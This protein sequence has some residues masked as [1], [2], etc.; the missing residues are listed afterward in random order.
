MG[1][2]TVNRRA[3]VEESRVWIGIPGV[4][5]WG[6]SLFCALALPLQAQNATETVT[7]TLKITTSGQSALQGSAPGNIYRE[8]D[9]PHTGD[10]WLV[11]RDS[12]N[13]AGPGRMVQVSKA[14]TASGAGPASSSGSNLETKSSLPVIHSG[15]SLIVIE[16]TA[17]VSEQLEAVALE[18]A[19]QGSIFEVRLNIGGR[20]YRA[21][22]TGPGRARFSE[23]QGGQ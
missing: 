19:A 16:E 9:D 1:K 3:R 14:A 18:S 21:V 17:A 10:R 22:A 2:G 6:V 12:N 4:S 23:G 11:V 7:R 15:D 20:T 5:L 8:I 13:P